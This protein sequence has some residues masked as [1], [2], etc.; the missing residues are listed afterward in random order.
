MGAIKTDDPY[1]DEMVRRLVEGL[2]PRAIYLFGSRARGDH[3]PD[4]D[5]DLLV[6]VEESDEPDYK[7]AHKAIRLLA[8]MP[9]SKE[10]VVL[11]EDEFERQRDI[12][13]SLP[14]SVSIEGLRIA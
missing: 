5:Y 9:V 1:L 8:G 11:T 7:R 3:R 6:V 10:V 2:Q 13:A 12:P 4:S 14:K